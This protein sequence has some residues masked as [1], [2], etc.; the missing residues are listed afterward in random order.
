[1]DLSAWENRDKSVWLETAIPAPDVRQLDGDVD[2]EVAVVGAGYT[3]CSAALH[4]AAAGKSVALL[5]AGQPGWGASGRSAG[6][7]C[8][9]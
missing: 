6:W 1:M 9:N 5:D 8:P 2:V 7:V 3:G 4:L